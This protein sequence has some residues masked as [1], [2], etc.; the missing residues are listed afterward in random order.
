MGNGGT[1]I[2][3]LQRIRH[4]I[5]LI[6]L[7]IVLV[8][9]VFAAP[10]AFGAAPPR[11]VGTLKVGG[12]VS[13]A[14]AGQVSAYRWVMCA[15]VS[16][17]KCLRRVKIGNTKTIVVPASAA[18]RSLMVSVKVKK[19]WVNSAWSGKVAAATPAPT[20]VASNVTSYTF[21]NSCVVISGPISDATL[22]SGS[23]IEWNVCLEIPTSDAPASPRAPITAVPTTASPRA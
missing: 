1:V 14:F 12:S 22:S 9:G 11:I 13:V 21:N 18:G 3:I 20:P 16:G 19:R 23:T 2:S 5:V 15:S 10:S 8:V 17:L 6:V 4:C 7:A